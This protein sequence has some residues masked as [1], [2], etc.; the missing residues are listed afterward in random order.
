MIYLK[1]GSCLSALRK[2]IRLS[3]TRSAR[4]MVPWKLGSSLRAAM[5]CVNQAWSLNLSSRN[6]VVDKTLGSF[7]EDRSFPYLGFLS[8]IASIKPY[9]GVCEC[10]STGK[11]CRDSGL[12]STSLKSA[13]PVSTITLV[14]S[15]GDSMS[16]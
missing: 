5:R 13:L 7:E 9:I 4:S 14:S 15:D 3:W 2:S 11:V 16:A 10:Q 6:W 1:H 12:S 8:H